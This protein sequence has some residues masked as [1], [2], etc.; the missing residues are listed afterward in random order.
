MATQLMPIVSIL[1]KFSALKVMVRVL[2]VVSG[3]PSLLQLAPK[4]DEFIGFDGMV[5]PLL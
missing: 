1:L 4:Y 2:L 3:P 5:M